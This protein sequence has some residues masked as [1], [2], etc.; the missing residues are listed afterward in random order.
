MAPTVAFITGANR[1]LGFGLAK[2][3]LAK[4]SYVSYIFR[5]ILFKG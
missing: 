4:P 1:G 5:G 2:L 3:F